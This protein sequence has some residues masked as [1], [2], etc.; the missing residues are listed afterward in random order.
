VPKYISKD[1]IEKI[2]I[3]RSQGWSLPEIYREVG[4]GYGSVSRYIKGV[5]VLPQYQQIWLD[6]RNGSKVKKERLE[7]IA[8]QKAKDLITNLNE[9]E[10]LLFIAALYWGEGGKKDFNFTNSDPEMIRIFVKCLENILKVDQKDIRVS[11]RIYE[12]LDRNTCLSHWSKI[13][14]IPVKEFVNVD[15]L[16]AK[17]TGKL[18]Y[19]LC[20]IRIKK[21]GNML[22]Y[23]LALNRRVSEIF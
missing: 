12:D 21:G 11:I 10:K 20:R 18:T 2:K 3:L 23:L 14:C 19:G 6:K 9:K 17:K 13:T 1:K 4:V 7:K 8:Y 22:K 16:K 5:V 15:V